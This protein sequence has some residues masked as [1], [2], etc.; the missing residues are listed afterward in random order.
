MGSSPQPPRLPSTFSAASDSCHPGLWEL[1]LLFLGQTGLHTASSL[2][3]RLS[4]QGLLLC[5]FLLSSWHLPLAG[6]NSFPH[7]LSASPP[8]FCFVSWGYCVLFTVL[9]QVSRG[10][11]AST[12]HSDS[13]RVTMNKTSPEGSSY[14]S[15]FTD[16]KMEVQRSFATCPRS[17]SLQGAGLEFKNRFGSNPCPWCPSSSLCSSP[18]PTPAS[19]II[20]VRPLEKPVHLVTGAEAANALACCTHT[21]THTDLHTHRHVQTDTHIQKSKSALRS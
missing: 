10:T 12:R 6:A 8:A 13:C 7:V 3:A 5:P 2:L 14:Y 9:S 17:H 15:H 4:G 19:P 18:S 16:R 1:C 21:C 20:C 11:S